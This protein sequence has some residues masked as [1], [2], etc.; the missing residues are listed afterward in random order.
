MLRSWLRGSYQDETEAGSLVLVKGLQFEIKQITVHG[1]AWIHG[2][3]VVYPLTSQGIT[4]DDVSEVNGQHKV[5]RRV[6]L[7]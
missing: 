5:Y 4:L 2:R 6:G 7:Q 1:Q 3:C